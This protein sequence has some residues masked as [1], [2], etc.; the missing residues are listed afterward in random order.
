M[1]KSKH[2]GLLE[3]LTRTIAHRYLVQMERSAAFTLDFEKPLQSLEQQLASLREASSENRLD[4]GM[5]IA[6]IEKKI[7]ATKREIFQ[8]LTAWQKVQISRHPRRPYALDYIGNIFDDFQELH[9]D[10]SFRDDRAL[11]G[12]TAF[13]EGKPVILLAQQKGRETR[14]KLARNFGMPN[15]EGYRKALR[16]MKLAEKF[17][18]PLIAFIDTPGAYPGVTSEERHVAEAIAV[19][20]REMARLPIPTVSVVIGE[21]GSG[22]ALGIG[23]TDRILVLEYAYYSVISPEGCA[24]ILWKDKAYAPK[25]A[26]A[27]RM[28][29]E[30]LVEFGVADEVIEEPLGGAHREPCEAADRVRDALSKQLRTLRSKSQKALLEERYQKFRKIGVFEVKVA[31]QSA[32]VEIDFTEGPSE[33]GSG[34]GLSQ[35]AEGGTEAAGDSGDEAFRNP[36]T[37][38]PSTGMSN[39]TSGNPVGG[40]SR[41]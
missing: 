36:G 19:N 2:S 40:T 39:G 27:L 14:D 38:P 34:S 23:V 15:P 12:G 22:G 26:A 11:I 16:L 25:A 6:A 8:N 29:A 3:P 24:A 21:G 13:F 20:L 18:L 10:R 35:E 1:F 5:E 17:R 37:D 4:V 31:E 9:G 28:S 7:E 33:E 30:D 32:E 41:L